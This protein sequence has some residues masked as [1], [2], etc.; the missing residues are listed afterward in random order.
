[1]PDRNT[2][3]YNLRRLLR[4]SLLSED[5]DPAPP[6]AT[7]SEVLFDLTGENPGNRLFGRYDVDQVREIA[8]K[9]G[10]Y[11]GLER[12]GYADPILSL[13]CADPSEQR[14]C[15][16]AG[17]MVR[18]RLLVEL[19]M[20]L[21]NF[22]PR[23]AIGPFTEATSFRMLVLLW[24]VLSNPEKDFPVDRPRL[25]GQLRPG[26]GLLDE[27]FLFLRTFSRDL[28]VDGTLDVP[29]HYHTALFYSRYFRYLDPAAEGRLE[30]I[31][32]DLAGVPLALAS[33]AIKGGCLVDHS[34][35]APLPWQPS[36][37]VMTERG[38]LGRFLRSHEYE[39]ARDRA[40]TALHVVVNWDLYREKL[41]SG[42]LGQKSP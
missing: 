28:A 12:L 1:M 38:P 21:T 19:R 24:L 23:H 2:M 29:E 31:A 25:P 27:M 40:R 14:I 37:Q 34:T 9:A 20:Q 10:L 32:R 16:Y 5:A 8:R 33:E 26:L 36:E 42:E 35:G 22:H 13:S 17:E 11:E 41:A 39:N 30:A 6:Q 18:E 3:R 15:L 7:E 4:F